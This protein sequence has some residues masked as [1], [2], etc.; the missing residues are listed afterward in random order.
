[1]SKEYD[2]FW[3]FHNKDDMDV[4]AVRLIEQLQAENERLKEALEA[5]QQC[6]EWA[7]GI[8]HVNCSDGYVPMMPHGDPEPCGWCALKKQIKQALKGDRDGLKNRMD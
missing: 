4:H 3:K 7:E 6:M 8:C 1:M 2:N 5:T